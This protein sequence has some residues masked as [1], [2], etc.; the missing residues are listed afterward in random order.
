VIRS[1]ASFYWEH[2][3]GR[4]DVI[5]QSRSRF[6]SRSRTSSRVSWGRTQ[7]HSMSRGGILS[8]SRKAWR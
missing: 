7:Y 5:G 3:R 8:I 1:E 6:E 4:A 2:P